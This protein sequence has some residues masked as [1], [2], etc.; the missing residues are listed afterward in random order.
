MKHCAALVLFL[1]LAACSSTPLEPLPAPEQW[2]ADAKFAP[3]AKPIAAAEVFAL[4]DAM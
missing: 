1:L 4:S 3:P 2:F